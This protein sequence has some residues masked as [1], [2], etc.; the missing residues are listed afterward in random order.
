M[1]GGCMQILIC[2]RFEMLELCASTSY[3]TQLKGI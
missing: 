1:S 3:V 2:L